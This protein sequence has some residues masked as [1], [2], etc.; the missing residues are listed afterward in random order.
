MPLLFHLVNLQLEAMMTKHY[1]LTSTVNYS[2]GTEKQ[3]E[4]EP[5]IMLQGSL[6]DEI[7]K[8]L[9]T[10]KDATSFVF[11]VTITYRKSPS[12]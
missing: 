1:S 11:V 7:I 8:V 4:G 10:V 12:A 6:E 3:I 2:D 9:D 5:F